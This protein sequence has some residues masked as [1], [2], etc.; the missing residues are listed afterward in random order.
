MAFLKVLR[1]R[2]L[3][4]L[5]LSQVLSAMG[6]YLYEIA[7][8]WIAV[9]SVGSGAGVVA[10]SEAGSMLIFGLLG[11]VYADRWDRQK[12]MVVA[13]VL[14]AIAVSVLP[15]LALS[16]MLQLWHLVI[17]AIIIGSLS[18]LFDPALQ[19]SLPALTTDIQT[20][21]ATN[22]LMDTTRRLARIL[23]PGTA[24]LLIALLP[25][26]HFFTL[27]A[28]SFGISAL[29]VLSL[30]RHYLW[31]AAPSETIQRGVRGIL[32][33]IGGALRLVHNHRP[34]AWA[35]GANGFI[36]FLWS[37]AF[38]VGV[39]LFTYRVLGDNVGAYGLIVGA[40]GVGNVLSN[41]VIGSLTIRHRVATIFAGKVIL[42][43]GFLLMA[44]AHTLWVALLGSALAA[45]GGPMGD[46]MTIVIMQTDLPANQ[47]GKVFSLRMILASAGGSLGLLFAVPLFAF[48]SVP[49]AIALCALTMSAIGVAGLVRFGF[50]EPMVTLG[51]QEAERL[52]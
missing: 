30:G 44:F 19:A 50:T 35:I 5:W 26:P 27:D 13:D 7:V 49:V 4:I 17:V 8:L 45:V 15:I 3:A 28:V 46:I 42:G 52:S 29:A 25:L 2:H 11:G 1:M 32:A 38:T 18:S 47:L 16:G 40:Y 22:G 6:D 20:L 34:L 43:G 24:G 41:I 33:E 36:N 39:P 23:G 12:V 37:A 31:K 48:L 51:T 21:Q 14:R 9:K 10:A